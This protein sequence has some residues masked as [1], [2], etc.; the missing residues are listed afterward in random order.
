MNKQEIQENINNMRNEIDEIY[1]SKTSH[2]I[3]E[4]LHETA[5]ETRD[6]VDFA[7]YKDLWDELA[8]AT[9]YIYAERY[10]EAASKLKKA[11]KLT[12]KMN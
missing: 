9:E 12:T 5:E 10:D 11:W 1:Y 6:M 4:A 3:W 8:M 7:D 2:E